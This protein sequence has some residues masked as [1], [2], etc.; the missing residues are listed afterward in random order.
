MI[1][2]GSLSFEQSVPG[3]RLTGWGLSDR[4]SYLIIHAKIRLM[5]VE[6]ALSHRCMTKL[7]PRGENLRCIV[8]RIRLSQGLHQ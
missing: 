3:L 5:Q 4:L 6:N 8:G 2:N 7:P 1:C